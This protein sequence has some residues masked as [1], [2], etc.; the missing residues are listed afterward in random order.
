MRLDQFMVSI[1]VIAPTD[2]QDT[3]SSC[4]QPRCE[5]IVIQRSFPSHREYVQNH[6]MSAAGKPCHV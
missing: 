4:S 1:A 3:G 2:R 6:N 5:I